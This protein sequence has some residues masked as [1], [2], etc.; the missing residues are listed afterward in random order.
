MIPQFEQLNEEETTLMLDTLPLITVLIAGADGNI[1]EEEKAWAEKLTNIRSF[2]REDSLTDYY[3]LADEHFA[4]KLSIFLNSLPSDVAAR[5]AEIG[6]RLSGLNSI[7]P[8]LDVNF[9]LR[10]RKGLNSFAEHVAKAS[11]GFLRMGSI[12]KE[13][14]DLIDLPMIDQVVV[15]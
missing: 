8:K 7:L 3:K 5:N 4:E 12:S 1:D 14:K 13:E 15:E 2:A 11:G 10:F 9:A 6:H